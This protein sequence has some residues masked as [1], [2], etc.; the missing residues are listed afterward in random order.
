MGGARRSSAPV[1][2]AEPEE[3][4]QIRGCGAED[5]SSYSEQRGEGKQQPGP[6]TPAACGRRR[7]GREERE[8]R[9]GVREVGREKDIYDF[10][11]FD[12]I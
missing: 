2:R 12:K 8:G 6:S 7:W 3:E 1:K 4:D 11:F 10:F 9:E 5:Q